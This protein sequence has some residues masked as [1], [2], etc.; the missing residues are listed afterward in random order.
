MVI[1]IAKRGSCRS[2]ALRSLIF[3]DLTDVGSLQSGGGVSESDLPDNKEYTVTKTIPDN[4]RPI[5]PEIHVQIGSLYEKNVPIHYCA[6]FLSYN[7]LLS[8][9]FSNRREYL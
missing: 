7:F 5:I 3:C 1:I 6:R 4:T 9:E 8:G 2:I